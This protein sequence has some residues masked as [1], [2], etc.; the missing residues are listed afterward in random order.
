MLSMWLLK[1]WGVVGDHWLSL[2]LGAGVSSVGGAAGVA[3]VPRYAVGPFDF[4][5]VAASGGAVWPEVVGGDAVAD[6]LIFGEVVEGGGLEVQAQA[7]DLAGKDY[8]AALAAG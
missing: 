7:V 8:V 6:G 3:C 1:R 4:F 2:W 5:E